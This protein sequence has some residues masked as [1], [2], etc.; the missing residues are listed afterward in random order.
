MSDL[1]GLK[2][3]LIGIMDRLSS[4]ESMMTS[5][6]SPKGEK[7]ALNATPRVQDENGDWVFD[8]TGLGRAKSACNK[9]GE[10]QVFWAI[11]KDGKPILI[12]ENGK[13]H[14]LNCKK[15]EAEVPF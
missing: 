5:G 1:E 15:E 10:R 13:P 11:K 3:I 7:K 9:C 2:E 8:P 6:D 14:F 4:I 12:D